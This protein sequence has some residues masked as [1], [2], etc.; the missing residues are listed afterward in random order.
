[1]SPKKLLLAVALLVVISWPS[2]SLAGS[3]CCSW[4]GGQSYCDTSVGRWVCEDGTYSPSCGCSYIPKKSAPIV[5]A[6]KESLKT[7][8]GECYKFFDA[9]T[10]D[11]KKCRSDSDTCTLAL[12]TTEKN[13]ETYY[14]ELQDQKQT[15]FYTFLFAI[16]SV[17]LNIWFYKRTPR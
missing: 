13:V 5:S 4:H 14:S 9:C 11:L 12:S 15:T 10:I 16:A 3:G 17:I 1:M 2:Y 6:T 7:D 8:T